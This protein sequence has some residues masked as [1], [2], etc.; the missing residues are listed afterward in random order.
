MSPV[1]ISA[2][3]LRD[4]DAVMA[5]MEHSFD[6]SYGEAWTAPQC[7]GLLPMTGVWLSLAR[8]D[9]QVVGFALS[10]IVLKEA[11]LLLLAVKRDGQGCGTGGALLDGFVLDAMMR[12]AERL[13]LE[14][15][16][17]NHAVNL[18]R[19]AGFTEAGRRKH[20]YRGRD[21]QVYDALTLSRPVG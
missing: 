1:T 10:R 11:E 15:R 19:R 3:D 21:G 4:L 8:C 18:Y 7:A 13:H 5:V 9:G 14:V 16:D 17:G 20:Y 2:G 6:P 12:G